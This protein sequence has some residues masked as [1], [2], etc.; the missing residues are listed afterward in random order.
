M[1]KSKAKNIKSHFFKRCLERTG[2]LINRNELI[3][4]IQNQQLEFLYKTSNTRTVYKYHFD[5]TN[6]D[7]KIVY[8][9]LRHDVVTIY[10]YKEPPKKKGS[11]LNNVRRS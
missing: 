6:K 4:K 7:Y 9:K 2:Y 10:D 8:D 5:I 3:Q 11:S 1:K